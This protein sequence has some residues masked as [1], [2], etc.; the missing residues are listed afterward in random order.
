D[1]AIDRQGLVMLQADEAPQVGRP[2]DLSGIGAVD[3]GAELRGFA[4]EAKALL[5]LAQ[6]RRRGL[7]RRCALRDAPL[8]LV[9]E[10]LQLPALAIELDEDGD[11]GA[12]DLG[13][14]RDRNV[15]DSPHL[16]AAYAVGIRD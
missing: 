4:G 6:L 13:Y 15:V 16:V 2:E 1:D 8:Q 7:Q 12:Q 14:D 9:V 3:V 11:F 5:A 10:L